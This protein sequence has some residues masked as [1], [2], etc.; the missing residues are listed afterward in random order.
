MTRTG[1]QMLTLVSDL[2][3]DDETFTTTGAGNSAA[4]TVVSTQLAKYGDGRLL[5]RHVRLTATPFTTRR[6]SANVQSTGTLTVGEAFAAQV[7]S[8][9]GFQLHKYE[10][11]KV[12]RAL[13]AAR[14]EV[15]DSAFKIVLDD[16]ITADGL[17]HP[18]DVP[19]AIEQGPHLVFF[20][21]P[22]ACNVSWNFLASPELAATT[23]WTA[24]SLTASTVAY[25]QYDLL[26]PKYTDLNATKLVATLNQAGTYRQTVANMTNGITAAKA[27]GRKVTMAMWVYC[28]LA[29]RI[30][31]SI[32]TDAGTLATG[33]A[34]Q[35]KGWELIFVEGTVAGDNATVLT[36]SLNVSSGAAL[37]AYA[38]RAWMYF[39]EKERV[40]DGHFNMEHPVRA[41]MD[42]TQR[43][44]LLDETPPRGTQLRVQG[45]APLTALGTTVTTQSTNTMEVDE[46]SALI[47]AAKAVEILLGD[48]MIATDDVG[49]I[50]AKLAAVGARFPEMKRQWAHKTPQFAFRSPFAG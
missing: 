24:A 34:H 31:L 10:P 16:T 20:E 39:G 41:R 45:K 19:T 48:G 8:S 12:F 32:L 6:C 21:T 46:K 13:D 37:T 15:M 25:S 49:A 4:T 11:A 35:G 7:A 38:Q 2:L 40:V 33:T 9:V 44:F 5:G 22:M 18:F 14:L 36:A 23:Y 50:Q 17:M 29:S 42:D 30:T 47:V 1:E 27:A 43:H 3:N 28:T 26:I